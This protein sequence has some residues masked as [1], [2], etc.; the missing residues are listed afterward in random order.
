MADRVLHLGSE[1]D[2]N[3]LRCQHRRLS[4]GPDTEKW[5]RAAVSRIL[6][7]LGHPTGYGD[8][9]LHQWSVKGQGIVAF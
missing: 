5:I 6:G 7:F 4:A 9:L 8:L 3:C 1:S 2:L